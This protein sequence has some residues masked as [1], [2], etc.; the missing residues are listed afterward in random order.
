MNKKLAASGEE[1]TYYRLTEEDEEVVSKI[2]TD[3]SQDKVISL[4]QGFNPTEE[5][6]KRLSEIN[7]KLK[8]LVPDTRNNEKGLD[9]HF[10]VNI[11]SWDDSPVHLDE[12]IKKDRNTTGNKYLRELHQERQYKEKL[13]S[14]NQ[15]LSEI[16]NREQKMNPDILSELLRQAK[17]EGLLLAEKNS[18]LN[19]NTTIIK[20]NGTLSANVNKM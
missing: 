6:A 12:N 8:Q 13:K 14:I 18:A 2:M 11:L 10:D 5:Q 16:Y 7:E 17:E 15:N 3:E 19:S 9:A 4:G 1:D 20:S